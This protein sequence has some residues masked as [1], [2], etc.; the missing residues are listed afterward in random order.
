VRFRRSRTGLAAVVLAFIAV[1]VACEEPTQVT[2]RISTTDKCSNLSDVHTYVGPDAKLTQKRFEEEV[3]TGVSDRCDERDGFIGTLVVTP[4]GSIGTILVAV[5]VQGGDG[6]PAPPAN[7]CWKPDVAKRCIIARR[8]FSF[9]ENKP[10]VL[11]VNLDPLCIGQS[12]DPASTC[13]KGSCVSAEVVC[14]GSECGLAEENPGG[15]P[16]GEAGND[17]SSSDGA[18]DAEL[19]G[20]GSPDAQD[21]GADS[22]TGTDAQADAPD[23]SDGGP[24][25]TV[26]CGIGGPNQFCAQGYGTVTAGLCNGMP[27]STYCCRCLCPSGATAT[28]QMSMANSSCGTSM[29]FC[30]P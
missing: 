10:L 27:A 30:P 17:G 4:G 9:I 6:T 18:Y 2:V 14:V 23:A 19:D 22:M 1:A 8:T 12:C 24:P 3:S 25:A 29:F 26:A 21:S 7:T 16:S 13:F 11:P 5:G 15:I 28:C 20:T